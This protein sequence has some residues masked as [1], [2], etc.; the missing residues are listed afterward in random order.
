MPIG[1]HKLTPCLWFDTQA[2]DAAS[3]C[4]SV[5]ENSNIRGISA[6]SKPL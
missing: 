6:S 4:V 3:L 2:E 1:K 5:F